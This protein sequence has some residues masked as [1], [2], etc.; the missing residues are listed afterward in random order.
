L[1]K[2]YFSF[3]P[4]VV[5]D[6]DAVVFLSLDVIGGIVVVNIR[7]RSFTDKRLYCSLSSDIEESPASFPVGFSV[8]DELIGIGGTKKN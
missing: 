6:G 1:I 8:E 3:K 5:L 2:S 7:A 4:P